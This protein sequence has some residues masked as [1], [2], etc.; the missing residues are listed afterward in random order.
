MKKICTFLLF[1]SFVFI[2]S[3]NRGN[4]ASSVKEQ[5]EDTQPLPSSTVKQ[6]ITVRAEVFH[7][8]DNLDGTG[9][10][11]DAHRKEDILIEVYDNGEMYLLKGLHNV[12]SYSQ[13]DGY[14]YECNIRNDIWAFNKDDVIKV[15][16]KKWIWNRRIRA[17]T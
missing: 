14:E 17:K 13:L 12:V 1:I 2:S 8:I 9:T 6:I 4:Q 15:E 3:C 7:Y 16:N 5:P 11:K 10:Y